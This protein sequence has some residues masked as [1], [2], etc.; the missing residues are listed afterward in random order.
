MILKFPPSFW[1]GASEGQTSPPQPLV[2]ADL[3]TGREGLGGGRSEQPTDALEANRQECSLTQFSLA[4][5]PVAF[6]R[7]ERLPVL[8]AALNQGINES[9]LYRAALNPGKK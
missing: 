1:C 8:D 5:T 2:I 9:K 3:L 4:L 6:D 7:S